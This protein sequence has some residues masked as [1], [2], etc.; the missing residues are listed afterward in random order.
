MKRAALVPIVLSATVVALL[1][2]QVATSSRLAKLQDQ[3]S[4][5]EERPAAGGTAGG[6][7][8]TPVAGA[9]TAGTKAVS[10]GDSVTGPGPDAGPVAGTASSGGTDGNATAARKP[11]RKSG[12]PMTEKDIEA[13]I[14]K[15]LAARDK[16]NP[17]NALMNFEDPMKVMERELKLTALQ[18][19]RILEHMKERDD[20]TM[21]LWQSEEA[22][23]D[24]RGI[25]EKS[26]EL[27]KKCDE[28][29]KREMDLT[30]QDKYEELKKSGKLMDFGGGG[31]S[32]VIGGFGTSS[33]DGTDPGG[34]EVPAGK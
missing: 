30:Q 6:E 18:K 4:K 3:V 10:S 12:E 29:I 7:S 11:G 22:R 2:L 32:V 16:K 17:L 33:E 15:K 14:E 5:L 24:W 19:T 31:R 34:A 23:K 26:D 9:E 13:L 8:A 1:A 25:Q 20:A 28:S 27:R 21:E